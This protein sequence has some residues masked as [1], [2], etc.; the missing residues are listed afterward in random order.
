MRL[1]Q[2]L[3]LQSKDEAPGWLSKSQRVLEKSAAELERTEP[4]ESTRSST[5]AGSERALSFVADVL[6]RYAT[7]QPPSGTS[8]HSNKDNPR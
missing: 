5:R 8:E 3:L 7:S 6:A 1:R 4:F 2:L